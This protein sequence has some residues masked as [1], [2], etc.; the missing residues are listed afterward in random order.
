MTTCHALSA[1]VGASVHAVSK[2]HLGKFGPPEGY[3]VCPEC[4]GKPPLVVR[5]GRHVPA[6]CRRCQGRGVVPTLPVG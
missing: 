6:H 2:G 4:L 3:R 5:D 1:G